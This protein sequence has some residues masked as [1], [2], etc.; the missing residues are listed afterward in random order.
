MQPDIDDLAD[1]AVL[2][3]LPRIEGKKK[4]CLL[5]AAHQLVCIG[6]VGRRWHGLV[7]EVGF[8]RWG[9]L[10]EN[11]AR[12]VVL[13]PM[14]ISSGVALSSRKFSPCWLSFIALPKGFGTFSS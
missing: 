10:G 14:S 6:K 9:M 5:G 13:F 12:S 2:A 7:L 3:F 1:D 8:L 4:D 11:Q